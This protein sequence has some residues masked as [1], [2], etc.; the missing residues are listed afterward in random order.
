MSKCLVLAWN[1]GLYAKAQAPSLSVDILV[2]PCCLY[3]ISAYS[4]LNHMHSRVALA[5]AAYSASVVDSVIKLCFFEPQTMAPPWARN[6]WPLMEAWF[7][8]LAKL[9]STYPVNIWVVVLLILD[10]VTS[11][12]TKPP[13]CWCSAQLKENMTKPGF[14]PRTS[15]HIPRC[16]N[17][18]ATGPQVL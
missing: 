8:V 5:S 12:L 13:C 4:F 17:H 10:H 1:W 7:S 6:T 18:W 15:W 14:E 9:A 2:G 3:P 11:G 16:S